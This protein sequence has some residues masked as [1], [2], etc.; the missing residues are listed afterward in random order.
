MSSVYW[1][2]FKAIVKLYV[3]PKLRCISAYTKVWTVKDKKPATYCSYHN[4]HS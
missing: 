1:C 3:Y 2:Y 4:L